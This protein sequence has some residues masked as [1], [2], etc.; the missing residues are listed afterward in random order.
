MLHSVGDGN[1]F[2]SPS[3]DGSVVNG[4]LVTRDDLHDSRKTSSNTSTSLY[5][6]PLMSDRLQNGGNREYPSCSINKTRGISESAK[7]DSFISGGHR[8]TSFQRMNIQDSSKS[9]MQTTSPSLVRMHRT[10]FKRDSAVRRSLGGTAIPPCW[11]NDDPLSAYD[12]GRVPVSQHPPIGPVSKPSDELFSL[13]TAPLLHI[14]VVRLPSLDDLGFSLD[15]YSHPSL[16]QFLG[17]RLCDRFQSRKI[18]FE[19]RDSCPFEVGDLIV[20]VNQHRLSSMHESQA[21]RYVYNAFRDARQY[22]V[23]FGVFRLPVSSGENSSRSPQQQYYE[24]STLPSRNSHARRF[25]AAYQL[26]SV[27]L[28]DAKENETTQ[29]QPRR[30]PSRKSTILEFAN[31]PNS[32]RRSFCKEV[33]SPHFSRSAESPDSSTLSG[34]PTPPP[35]LSSSPLVCLNHSSS[36]KSSC[37]ENGIHPVASP[38]SKS[39]CSVR[40]RVRGSAR[41]G[42]SASS[43][44]RMYR[45]SFSGVALKDMNAFNT[46]TIGQRISV[47]LTKLGDGGFGFTVTRRDTQTNPEGNDPVY[48]KKILPTGAAILDGRLSIGDRL[49]AVDGIDVCNLDQVLTQLRAVPAGRTVHLLISRQTASQTD[50]PST[51]RRSALPSLPQSAEAPD[52]N[53]VDLPP[54]PFRSFTF[55][56]RLPSTSNGI[57]EKPALGVNFKWNTFPPDSDESTA[58]M[59]APLPG[60]Y[61][62]N[63]LPDGLVIQAERPTLLPGDR[64]VGLNGESLDGLHAKE[65]SMKIKRILSAVDE[66]GPKDQSARR[67]SLTVHRYRGLHRQSGT[68]APRA[69]IRNRCSMI[70]PESPDSVGTL[71]FD[72]YANIPFLTDSRRRRSCVIEG[73]FDRSRLNVTSS[74]S[75]EASSKQSTPSPRYLSVPPRMFSGANPYFD[76]EGFGRRSVSEKRHGQ[77]DAAQL[78][79]FQNQILPSRYKMPEDVD[80]QYSTMPTTRRLKIHRERL[81]AL[82]ASNAGLASAGPVKAL[83][84]TPLLSRSSD[85]KVGDIQLIQ[86]TPDKPTRDERAPRE[87]NA[88]LFRRGR[89]QNNSFRNAVDRSLVLGKTESDPVDGTTGRLGRSR[90]ANRATMKPGTLS[91]AV[92]TELSMYERLVN[93]SIYLTDF[94]HSTR[95]PNFTSL[96]V[97]Q[98]G[99]CPPVPPRQEPLARRTTSPYNIKSAKRNFGGIRGLFRLVSGR[100]SQ[101]DKSTDDR[102]PRSSKLVPNPPLDRRFSVPNRQLTSPLPADIVITPAS[103]TAVKGARVSKPSPM[104]ISFRETYYVIRSPSRPKKLVPTSPMNNVNARPFSESMIHKRPEPY[105]TPIKFSSCSKNHRNTEGSVSEPRT[106]PITP[107]V[108]PRKHHHTPQEVSPPSIMQNRD[109]QPLD[110]KHNEH[111]SSSH[112]PGQ[113]GSDRSNPCANRPPRESVSDLH[114]DRIALSFR[115]QSAVSKHHDTSE[116]NSRHRSHRSSKHSSH[117]SPISPDSIPIYENNRLRHVTQRKPETSECSQLDSS[118]LTYPAKAVRN[119]PT[120]SVK[121]NR[122][123]MVSPNV[124]A[125][126]VTAFPQG[127]SAHNA[128]RH[129][130]VVGQKNASLTDGTTC[131]ENRRTVQVVPAVGRYSQ[132]I[133]EARRRRRSHSRNGQ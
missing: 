96:F 17:L 34:A 60:L 47:E 4:I 40:G 130:R 79:F 92:A 62:E 93:S 121:T 32:P 94:Q 105:A 75:T 128:S 10:S 102:S 56:F 112:R 98:D 55:E 23:E 120:S 111:H 22:T 45:R 2:L 48:I 14:R 78:P 54:R 81:A 42:F 118:K 33:S 9:D 18:H 36:P 86:S 31:T 28:E 123:T 24:P 43:S 11:L 8:D 71:S 46:K 101:S 133:N 49:L 70:T 109:S 30:A 103:Q 104:Q 131:F 106:T 59:Y 73:T 57:L 77:V 52:L 76:R 26:E 72:Q 119:T 16:G 66:S 116:A 67:F 132:N 82:A 100:S 83:H 126:S 12:I 3:A 129:K 19:A 125:R 84:P 51:D 50:N 117:V 114:G 6:K 113:S 1:E 29:H 108:P 99:E 21:I 15:S 97:E 7:S 41:S 63:L 39:G 110:A 89:K 122:S 64:L 124:L 53:S 35:R 85:S 80:K 69:S 87:W 58:S 127:S 90:S 20:S 74:S 38:S 44:L 27:P 115:H 5:V 61:V 88:G 107:P 95:P 65:I 37:H 13:D 25:S 91:D 68:N